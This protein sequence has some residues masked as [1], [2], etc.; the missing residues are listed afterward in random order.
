MLDLHEV[1]L[2]LQRCVREESD[3]VR[4]RRD[5]E[6]H[7]VEYGDAEGTDVLRVRT[8]VA[9]HEDVLF[10]EELYCGQAVR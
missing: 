7:E 10:S 5:F 3:E 8:F 2:E 1:N 6:G 9:Q 4:L